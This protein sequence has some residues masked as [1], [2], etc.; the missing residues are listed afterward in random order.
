MRVPTVMRSWQACPEPRPRLWHSEVGKQ[1]A[2]G[3]SRLATGCRS[4]CSHARGPG[5][6]LRGVFYVREPEHTVE[7][8][9]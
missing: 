8:R 7:R 6:V 2:L 3:A 9:L 4:C 1:D 5:S